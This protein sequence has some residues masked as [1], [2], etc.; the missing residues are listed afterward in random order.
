MRLMQ[1]MH[2]LFCVAFCL[3][4][5]FVGNSINAETNNNTSNVTWHSQ[6]LIENHYISEGR[7]NLAGKGLYSIAAEFNYQAFTITPWFAEGI[8][9][10]Y[11]EFN[12]N[13]NY[14]F[15]LFEKVNTS[16]GYS[17]LKS[18]EPELNNQNNEV[19]VEL[20]YIFNN[21]L[22]TI[23]SSYYSFEAQ[24]LFSEIS[25]IKSYAIHNDFSLDLK[26]T[27]G[28]NGDYINDGHNGLNYAQLHANVHYQ[29]HNKIAL[30]AYTSYSLAINENS[31]HYLGDEHLK[32]IFWYGL[33]IRYEM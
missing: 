25:V 24:G 32:N 28:I 2:K 10:D 26:T 16:I 8:N 23:V 11:S 27:L 30:Y 6:F 5:M 9:T 4:I 15:T 29:I 19:N 13:F 18:Y 12:L 3:I 14:A 33:G 7:D 1:V 21:N 22:A 20:S 17:Y 31:Q